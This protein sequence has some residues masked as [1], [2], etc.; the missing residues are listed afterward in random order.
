VPGE[1]EFESRGEGFFGAGEEQLG[2]LPL[3]YSYDYL[4][5][6]AADR[7]ASM[8]RQIRQETESAEKFSDPLSEPRKLMSEIWNTLQAYSHAVPWE[9]SCAHEKLQQAESKVTDDLWYILGGRTGF[10]APQSLDS[11]SPKRRSRPPLWDKPDVWTMGLHP[12]PGKQVLTVPRELLYKIL[13]VVEGYAREVP[14][15]WVSR[16][17]HDMNGVLRELRDRLG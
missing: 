10:F 17:A 14:F 7:K 1:A 11:V 2:C 6:T 8:S 5:A 9:W 12:Q 16:G 3:C 13:D 15:G 4:G